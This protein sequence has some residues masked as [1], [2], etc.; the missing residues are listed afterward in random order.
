MVNGEGMDFRPPNEIYHVATRGNPDE[1]GMP[2]ANAIVNVLRVPFEYSTAEKK[3][4]SIREVKESYNGSWYIYHMY[5]DGIKWVEIPYD[6]LENVVLN[7]GEVLSLTYVEDSDEDGI[8]GRMEATLG[9]NIGNSDSDGDGIRD[10]DEMKMNLNPKNPDSDWDGLN[11]K[12]DPSPKVKNYISISA[13]H[14]HNLLVKATGELFSWGDNIDHEESPAL[15]YKTAAKSYMLGHSADYIFQPTRVGSAT[16]WRFVSA[17]KNHS[18]AIKSDGTMWTW[19]ANWGTF[20]FDYHL[21][22]G[23]T[24]QLGWNTTSTQTETPTLVSPD[25]DWVYVSAGY[26]HTQ[27]LKRDG[28][29]WGWG[30]N[31]WGAVGAGIIGAVCSPTLVSQPGE[32]WIDVTAGRNLSYAIKSDGSLWASGTDSCYLNRLESL[33]SGKYTGEYWYGWCNHLPGLNSVAVVADCPDC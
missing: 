10:L 29:L 7:A 26:H 2:L 9:L 18:A 25:N 3:V 33:S 5:F 17:G 22:R 14:N 20:D 6:D 11:D 32:I 21:L 1:P 8:T 31:H 27:A 30:D 15:A 23:T 16:D 13:G 28:S 12:I 24:C 19:G 4:T